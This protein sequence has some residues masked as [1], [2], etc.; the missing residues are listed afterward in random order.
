MSYSFLIP[1][2]DVAQGVIVIDRGIG[3][4]RRS[5]FTD[6]LEFS[7]HARDGA[8]VAFWM[9]AGAHAVVTAFQIEGKPGEPFFHFSY[10]VFGCVSLHKEDQATFEK[11]LSNGRKKAM[12]R[13]DL[14]CLM[15]NGV[16]T[17]KR[18]GENEHAECNANGQVTCEPDNSLD[19]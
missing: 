4:F 2:K 5:I 16:W 8:A 11:L 10:E 14:W 12:D 18:C 9:P 15:C 13:D 6:V 17:C 7:M 1:A 19:E 3:T